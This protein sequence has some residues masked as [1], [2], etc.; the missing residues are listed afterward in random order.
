MGRVNRFL[1]GLVF[2]ALVCAL[3]SVALVAWRAQV[4]L[5]GM[6][7]MVKERIDLQAELT[8]KELRSLVDNKFALLDSTVKSEL[9]T[10]RTVLSHELALTR[11]SITDIA[12]LADSRAESIQADLND[13]LTRAVLS[14]NSQLTRTNDIL[15]EQL[16][17]TNGAI[18]LTVSNLNET[19]E[20]IKGA[21]PLFLDCDHNPDCVFNRYVGIAR[22]AEH[23]SESID[24]ISK[25]VNTY[26]HEFTKP[27]PWWQKVINVTTA[28]AYAVIQVLY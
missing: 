15:D 1:L 17:T 23:T 26:V 10:S 7:N 18:L 3:S 16:T 19:I 27:K 21:L 8:R 22:A 11:T 24:S 20:P 12:K 5:S 4:E 14:A 9:S 25:D 6:Q 2:L 13:Q 28:A